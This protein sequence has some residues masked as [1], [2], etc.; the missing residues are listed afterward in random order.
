ML[1]YGISAI[2]SRRLPLKKALDC[3]WEPL[4]IYN[5]SQHFAA[6][7][8]EVKFE[9][10]AGSRPPQDRMS[11][12]PYLILSRLRPE[13]GDILLHLQ[14]Y[15]C[16]ARRVQGSLQVI[17]IAAIVDQ[18][19]SQTLHN[20]S[21]HDWLSAPVPDIKLQLEQSPSML[22]EYS[23][24]ETGWPTELHWPV[25]VNGCALAEGVRLFDDGATTPS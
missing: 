5:L 23:P 13:P 24:G 21:V 17:D 6:Y 22:D 19:G 15:Y 18:V 16:I 9:S 3:D 20:V 10:S 7:M 25:R 4:T 11:I 14:P 8:T 12:Y 2:Y 1:E